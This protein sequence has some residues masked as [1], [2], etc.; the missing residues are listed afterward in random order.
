M[1][2]GQY[3]RLFERT[4]LINGNKYFSKDIAEDGT[5]KS[6]NIQ[7]PDS[8]FVKI[9]DG[10]KYFKLDYYASIL[11]NKKGN[12]Y[13]LV[14]KT[15]ETQWILGFK[16]R[17][18]IYKTESMDG[19]LEIDGAMYAWIPENFRFTDQYNKEKFMREYI[20][21]DGLA[22]QRETIYKN[23]LMNRFTLVKLELFEVTE[24][25]ISKFIKE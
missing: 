25:D 23:V 21:P 10:K 20:F 8:T 4:L 15:K 11:G 5:T 7:T 3:A 6:Y 1:M 19:S 14:E 24:E 13:K 12:F 16:C 18:Y 22:F 9:F 17:K 2:G